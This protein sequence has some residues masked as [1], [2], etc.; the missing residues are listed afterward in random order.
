MPDQCLHIG[1]AHPTGVRSDIFGEIERFRRLYVSHN[2]TTSGLR[3]C[4]VKRLG[5]HGITACTRDKDT[6][7]PPAYVLY[8]LVGYTANY[9]GCPR[10]P[11]RKSILNNNKKAPPPV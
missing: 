2:R 9:L 5:D 1:A 3:P 10:V 4:C 7:G 8:E 11:K 6:N